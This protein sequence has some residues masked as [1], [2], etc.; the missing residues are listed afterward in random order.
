MAMVAV[1]PLAALAIAD[2][3]P[4]EALRKEL[5][6]YACLRPCKW[7]PGV[8]SRYQ[9]VVALEGQGFEEAA[10]QY[11]RQSEQIPTRVRLAIEVP[12]AEL[13]DH[14]YRRFAERA[15]F[16]YSNVEVVRLTRELIAPMLSRAR[17][18]VFH[19]LDADAIEKLFA[20]AE[21][22]EGKKLP[23]DAEARAVLVR[24]ADGDGRADKFT[25]FADKLNLPTGIVFAR[26]GIIDDIVQYNAAPTMNRSRSTS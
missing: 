20:H 3:E 8:R 21:Q 15:G 17:V 26:K 1:L 5:E 19:S 10:H 25:V 2:V 24:M 13:E 18:L 6:L 12:F 9:G 22:A 16:S 11:F 14:G 7:Y 23:L 4:D